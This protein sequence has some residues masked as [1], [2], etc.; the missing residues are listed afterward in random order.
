MRA[1]FYYKIDTKSYIMAAYSTTG[2]QKTSQLESNHQKTVQ[3]ETKREADGMRVSNPTK[4][5]EILFDCF[6]EVNCSTN[7][8]TGQNAEIQPST[9]NYN[10]VFQSVEVAKPE[11]NSSRDLRRN[12]K[13][14]IL[15]TLES[16]T[17]EVACPPN[18]QYFPLQPR[19]GPPLKEYPFALDPFQNES[20][21][22][23][24]NNQSVLV[25]AHTSA[26]KTVIAE[27]AVA[28]AFKNE[29]KII[30]TTPIKALSNQKY[31]EFSEQFED[32]G[33]VTGDVTLNPEASCLIMTTEI[34]RSMLYRGSEI[35]REVG[36]VI[37][38]EIHYMRDSE[39]GVVW[40][41]SIILLPHNVRF[42]FLSATIPNARQFAEWIAYLYKQ[43][44]HVVYT[45]YRPT[46]LQYYLFAAGANGIHMVVDDKGAFHEDNFSTAMATLQ[47]AN[48][49]V[50]DKKRGRQG[51]NIK[52]PSQSGIFKVVK[53]IMERGFA[54][55]IVFSFS[56]KDCE[57][58]AMQLTKMDFNTP[59]EKRCVQLVFD[60]AMDVLSDEDKKLPQVQNMLPLLLRGIGI[61]HGGLL[62]ILKENIEILFGEGLIKAL[63]A[64]ET[65]AMGLNMPARTV[66]FT[67]I[68]KFDGNQ[69]RLISSAEYIQ[70]SGRAGRRGLDD[71]GIVILMVDEAIS[72]AS[73]R[74]L[75]KGSADP[76]NSAFHL[77]YNMILNLMR[78]EEM[79]PEFMLK[80]S[81][82]QFQYQSHFPSLQEDYQKKKDEFDA[83]EVKNLDLV[84]TYY[85][86][87]KELDLL[88]K[89]YK[90]FIN[91]PEYL[92][93]F[94]QPGRLVKIVHENVHYNWGLVVNFKKHFTAKSTIIDGRIISEPSTTIQLRVLL[95]LP[96][97]NGATLEVLPVESQDIIHLSEARVHC[98]DDIK[99]LPVR[100]ALMRAVKEIERRFPEGPSILDPV[101]SM[102]I[103]EPE[104]LIIIKKIK[105]LESKL[106]AHPLHN[107][108]GMYADYNKYHKKM[109]LEVAL[110][111]AAEKIAASKILQKLDELKAR[112]QV[113]KRLGYCSAKDV[114][115]LKGR[116]ACE[117]SCGDELVIT[118]V[119]FNGIFN[120]L[121]PQQATAFLSCFV[122]DERSKKNPKISEELSGPL[123]DLQESARLI[124]KASL[125]SGLPIDED[126][127]VNQFKPHLM[128]VVLSWCNGASFA[129]ICNTSE[130]F[131]GS[132][133]RCMR[134][135][136]E[137]LRQL[138]Q[139][140]KTIGNV[141][142]ETKFTE[143]IKI[144]KRDIVFSSSLYL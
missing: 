6:E 29:Q 71:Q 16:C 65:F 120:R 110:H 5:V 90:A 44:C 66:L 51:G 11:E 70:M 116:V 125:E 25:S 129:E 69:R 39:R 142:M 132:I 141:K 33:L 8:S 64:T 2:I 41:E 55:V 74:D 36:W 10:K 138:V 139:A 20:I 9:V 79:N 118:E 102:G 27:Y 131:E 59:A 128:E 49:R 47:N 63:F 101:E 31:R 76:I 93:P 124:A 96:S 85:G 26:G 19:Y 30:Y 88:S 7:P 143:A 21:V 75:M 123:R 45:D 109:T 83:I 68:N 133:V 22:C 42:V 61:H 50:K 4:C 126:E 60:N 94:M 43:P 78:I 140:S 95:I 103:K 67:G 58:Y 89:D 98:P 82:Y 106:F 37:F 23:V 12:I 108:N 121:T 114:I 113:L 18:E 144:M 107:S 119:F 130:I 117:L 105:L 122:C 86:I 57:L 135:L 34:L 134:R 97:G 137:L 80:R 81:F 32:V 111:E 72:P 40:E 35:M 56:K 87:R 62:P 15:K 91:K 1:L 136:E 100:K 24:D 38:D 17:H 13:V 73:L 112:K 104:F 3:K 127:Y 53:M 84:T 48:P 99:P 52:D 28:K 46:P 77:T 115:Q 54:P 92:I 14:H